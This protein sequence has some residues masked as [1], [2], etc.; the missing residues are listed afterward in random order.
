MSEEEKTA[1]W[2]NTNAYVLYDGYDCFFTDGTIVHGDLTSAPIRTNSELLLA[3][4]NDAGFLAKLD[5]SIMMGVSDPVVGEYIRFYDILPA[6]SNLVRIELRSISDGAKDNVASYYWGKSTNGISVL[7]TN[8]NDIKLTSKYAQE[9]QI[10]SQNI[11]SVVAVGGSVDNINA[12]GSNIDSVNATAENIGSVNTVAT[13]VAAV[14]TTAANI[15]SVN[16]TAASVASVNTVADNIA[17]VNTTAASIGNV[18]AVGTS[19][20]DV[21]AV[22]AGLVDVHTFA[23]TYYGG[24]DTAP[25]TETHPTLSAGDMYFNTTVGRFEGYSGSVWIPLTSDPIPVVLSKM[26]I[27]SMNYDSGN[28]LVRIDYEGTGNYE[29]FTYDTDGALTSIDH[30][31]DDVLAGTTTLSYTNGNLTSV[32]FAEA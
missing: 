29:L 24:L 1:L 17:D 26:N 8:I 25:T 32:V 19:I 20:A 3:L 6:A 16:T 14:S 12:V 11:D 4:N 23:S 27:A 10:T 15:D 31:K 28:N 13:N 30:Y 7:A 5:N 9:I 18:N 2:N 21:S 22:A